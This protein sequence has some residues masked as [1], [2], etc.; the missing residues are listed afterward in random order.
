MHHLW[1]LIISA[2]LPISFTEKPQDTHADARA[3]VHQIQACFVCKP[4]FVRCLL[5]GFDHEI[6]MKYSCHINWCA[7]VCKM[8]TDDRSAGGRRRIRTFTIQVHSVQRELCA[9]STVILRSFTAQ[10]LSVK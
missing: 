4:R 8:A 9:Q 7:Y 5:P 1:L 6:L 10:R 2:K 3:R